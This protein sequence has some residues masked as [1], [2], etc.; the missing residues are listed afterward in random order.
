[1]TI[2]GQSQPW[3]TIKALHYLPSVQLL[4]ALQFPYDIIYLPHGCEAYAIRFILPSNNQL[5]IDSSIKAL[6]NRLGFNR[7]YSKID[8]F[9]MMQSLNISNLNDMI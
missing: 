2:L 5:N 8:N 1:M 9:S 7:S 4:L 3:K 6:E